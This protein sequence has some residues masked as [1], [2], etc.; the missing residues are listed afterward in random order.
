MITARSYNG[1]L[2]SVG[3]AISLCPPHLTGVALFLEQLVALRPAE[4]KHLTVITHKA[5]TVPGINRM[6]AEEALF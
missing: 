2:L 3:L 5:H 1:H 4:P 6:R